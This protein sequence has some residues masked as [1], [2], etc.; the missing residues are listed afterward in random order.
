MVRRPLCLCP[1]KAL[2]IME[3]VKIK[4]VLYT[5]IAVNTVLLAY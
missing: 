4:Y 1:L 3:L 2:L 5:E